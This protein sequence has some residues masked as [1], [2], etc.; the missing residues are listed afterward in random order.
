MKKIYIFLTFLLLGTAACTDLKEEVLD[1]V[2]G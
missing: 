2:S 1:E